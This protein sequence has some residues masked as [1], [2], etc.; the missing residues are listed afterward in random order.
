MSHR[1]E[2]EISRGTGTNPGGMNPGAGSSRTQD[3]KEESAAIAHT[4]TDA[5]KDVGQS[6]KEEGSAV[7]AEAKDQF[8]DLYGQ[9]RDELTDQ[10]TKQQERIASGLHAMGNDLG[11]MARSSEEDGLASE[12]VR[13]TSQ[14]VSQL[15]SWLSDREPG[16]VLN[17]VKSYARR[18]PGMFIGVAAVA[19]LV[20]GRLTRALAANAR[21]EQDGPGQPRAE[22]ASKVPTGGERPAPLPGSVEEPLREPA[23]A[24]LPDL[25]ATTTREET[26]ND[27][28]HTF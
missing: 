12:L 6:A 8:Q 11:V 3:A 13:E 22:S 1:N 26:T 23:T 4:A 2:P 10:A 17:E 19:G 24:P 15:A 5:A 16:D 25:P 27:R 18:Q 9:T 7:A 20:A 28:P 14:R 21:D